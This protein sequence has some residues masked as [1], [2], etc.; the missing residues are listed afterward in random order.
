[1]IEYGIEYKE[2]MS[3]ALINL[4]SHEDWAKWEVGALNAIK[5]A[6][7]KSPEEV[8]RVADKYGRRG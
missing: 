1:M 6:G 2:M 8:R 3:E 5:N 4:Y 7:F